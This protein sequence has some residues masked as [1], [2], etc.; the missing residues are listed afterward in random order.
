MFQMIN[1]NTST[2]EARRL[3]LYKVGIFVAALAAVAG[4]MY[5]VFTGAITT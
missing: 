5:F 4:V 2:E 3:L 1:E